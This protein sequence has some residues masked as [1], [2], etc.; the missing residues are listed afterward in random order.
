MNP[1]NVKYLPKNTKGS[2]YIV[3]DVHGSLPLLISALR[4][5]NFN[6]EVD[7]LILLGDLV[8]RGS[9]SI[10]MLALLD[11][12][13]VFSVRGN[14][15]NMF[16]EL[17]EWEPN[18]SNELLLKMY[19]NDNGMQWWLSISNEIREE[20]ISKFKDLPIAIEIE[21]DRG[22]VGVV[23]A[24]VPLGVSWDRL[25]Y[26]LIAENK[27]MIKSCLWD[28]VRVTNNIQEVIKG[29]DRVY[30]GH[31]ILDAGPRRFGNTFA[32]DTGACLTNLHQ[33]TGLTIANLMSK[34]TQF[35]SN[36]LDQGLYILTEIASSKFSQ[37]K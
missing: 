18:P 34:T 22:L 1:N 10:Q 14:H 33:G 15:E 21:T 7:R 8:D 4:A 31:C 29:I 5:V 20:A 30:V 19:D 37:Y 36:T 24:E 9:H 17:H 26:E 25:K 27:E 12:P 32:I 35:N 16:L 28:R 11:F 2:D 6:T 13:W 23:H 3:G